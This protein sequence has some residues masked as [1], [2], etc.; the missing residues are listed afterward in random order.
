MKP[1]EKKLIKALYEKGK[2]TSPTSVFVAHLYSLPDILEELNLQFEDV[3]EILQNNPYLVWIEPSG[4][5]LSPDGLE[6]CL[7][8]FERG[9]MGFIRN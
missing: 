9:N 3:E 4:I 2:A 5:R 8:E 6:Y 1:N 7:D